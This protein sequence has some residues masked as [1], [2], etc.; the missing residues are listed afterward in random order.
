MSVTRARRSGWNKSDGD[1]ER[2]AIIVYL[3]V[4]C[5]R[6]LDGSVVQVVLEAVAI[7]HY[8]R[9][10]EVLRAV[11]ENEHMRHELLYSRSIRFQAC[12]I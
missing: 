5:A 2:G 6:D 7:P 4:I 10:V 9:R 1:G 12:L 3:D 8:A 11:G